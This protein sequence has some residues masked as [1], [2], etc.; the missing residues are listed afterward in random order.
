VAINVTEPTVTIEQEAT[1]SF[2]AVPRS[3]R[4]KKHASNHEGPGSDDE[5]V[6]VTFQGDAARAVR[7]MAASE[8]TTPTELARR[9]LFLMDVY[10]QLKEDQ[11]LVVMDGKGRIARLLFPWRY[12][13]ARR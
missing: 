6:T 12:F 9:A 2:I 8:K 3:A 11:E 7:S 4:G 13:S 5:K 1:D 10:L